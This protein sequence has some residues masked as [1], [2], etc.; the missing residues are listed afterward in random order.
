MGANH[1]KE[2]PQEGVLSQMKTLLRSPNNNNRP[3]AVGQRSTSRTTS[4]G[5]PPPSPR[6]LADTLASPQLQESFLKFLQ[7]LDH[8][9]GIPT[10]HCGRAGSLEFVLAVKQFQ[11]EEGERRNRSEDWLRFFPRDNKTSGL[12]LNNDPQLWRR[13]AEATRKVRLRK[14]NLSRSRVKFSFSL[15]GVAKKSNLSYIYFTFTL[16]SRS[17]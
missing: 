9:S 8:N 15:G 13:C 2:R 6:T 1:S 3:M 16:F 17:S 14:S 11:I 7:D 10:D 5:S 12:V 4:L